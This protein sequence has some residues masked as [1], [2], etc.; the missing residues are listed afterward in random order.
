MKAHPLSD[1]QALRRRDRY[2]MV[3]CTYT[4]L[5]CMRH[6]DLI[7]GLDFNS[8]HNA[9]ESISKSGAKWNQKESVALSRGNYC[10]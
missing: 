3:Q 8:G 7:H 9:W 10:R 5:W 6:Y 1:C 4:L 2:C